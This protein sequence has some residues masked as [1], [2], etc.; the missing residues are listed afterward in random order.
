MRP[1]RELAAFVEAE[2]AAFVAD[3]QVI[4]QRDV[5]HVGGGAQAEREPRIVGTRGGIA[6]RMV[7]DDHQAGRA[8]CETR[9]QK[10]VRQGY[11]CAVARSTREQ[12]PGE[13]A[14]TSGQT[15]DAEGLDRL[16]S[17][18]RAEHRRRRPWVE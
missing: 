15:G 17:D 10:H 6:A 18:Q 1:L 4:E 5:E 13:Q 12:M 14:T 11:W 8:R 7:V 16:I 9:G 2:I 3:D